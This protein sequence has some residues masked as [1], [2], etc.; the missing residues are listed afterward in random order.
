[1]VGWVMV[2]MLIGDELPS[3]LSIIYVISSNDCFHI[4][5]GESCVYRLLYGKYMILETHITEIWD[6]SG[7]EKNI[8]CFM[9][10]ILFIFVFLKFP[11][12]PPYQ[13]PSPVNPTVTRN[14]FRIA[15][16]FFPSLT[17]PTS[18]IFI[19]FIFLFYT[20]KLKIK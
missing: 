11:S 18:S 15:P 16:C 7:N 19:F 10:Y 4:D 5:F 13:Q 6:L 14:M 2:A 9:H 8:M 3:W 1:M 12:I 17:N 20:F